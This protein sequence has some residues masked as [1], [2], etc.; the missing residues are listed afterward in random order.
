MIVLTIDG[1]EQSYG[2]K[3]EIELCQKLSIPVVYL[4][5]SSLETSEAP[6]SLLSSVVH[7]FN[8][9]SK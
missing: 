3:A 8:D 4:D 6:M 5:P 1:W 2:V 7:V 9:V